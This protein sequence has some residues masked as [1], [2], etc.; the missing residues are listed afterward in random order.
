MTSLDAESAKAETETA[1]ETTEPKPGRVKETAYNGKTDPFAVAFNAA[2]DEIDADAEKSK[3]GPKPAAKKAPQKP[4]AKP[5]AAEDDGAEEA[6]P[7]PKDRSYAKDTDTEPEKAEPEP[8]KTRE[9][10]KYWSEKRKDAFRFQPREVQDEWLEAEPEPNDRWTTDDKEAFSKL[11]REAKEIVLAQLNEAEKGVTQKFQALAAERKLAEEVRNAVPPQMRNYMQQRGLGEAQVFTKLLGYQQQAMT[12]PVG[13]VRQFIVHNKLNP[14]DVLGLD[15][16]G[17]PTGQIG[18]AQADVTSHPAFQA[19]KAENDTLH[20]SIA[21]DRAQRDQ[22]E[23]RRF[24]SEFEGIIQETDG[25]GS[26]LY[27][28]IRLLAEPMARIIEADPEHFGS[29]GVRE[30]FSAAYRS[31]LSEFP[32]LQSPRRTATPRPADEQDDEP[33]QTDLEGKRAAKLE[34]AI[35]PKSRTPQSAAPAKGKGSDP[36]DAA[37]ASARKQLSR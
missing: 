2:K 34:K 33:A 15:Q 8:K 9:P 4:V 17:Q 18:A 6:E 31:A 21:Q 16:N 3:P 20:R 12:D 19:L 13:Y 26:S 24:A 35:T 25:E 11:P 10:K 14:A 37:I 29:M 36:L 22:E 27:P 32:E 1:A 28:Y 30:R 23:S 7:Q 5:T